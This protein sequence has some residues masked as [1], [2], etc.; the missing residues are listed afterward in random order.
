MN[1]SLPSSLPCPLPCSLSCLLI[2]S[3]LPSS[4]ILNCPHCNEFIIVHH[5]EIQCGIFRHGIYTNNLEPVD[6]HLSQKQCESLV[7]QKMIYG[8][9]KPFQLFFD[10]SNNPY[11]QKCDYI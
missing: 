7:M 11:T 4:L 9:G 5:E 3:I 6:P 10:S 2:P 8:C 1:S